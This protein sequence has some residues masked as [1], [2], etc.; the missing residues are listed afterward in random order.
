MKFDKFDKATIEKA[1]TTFSR[2]SLRM[3][4]A[5]INADNKSWSGFSPMDTEIVAAICREW[6]ASVEQQDNESIKRMRAR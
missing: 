1:I 4:N 3:R 2:D 6:M 5:K